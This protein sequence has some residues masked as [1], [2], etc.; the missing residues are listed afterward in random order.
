MN[1][2]FQERLENSAWDDSIAKNVYGRFEKRRKLQ[3]R[4][5]VSIAVLAISVLSFWGYANS[6]SQSEETQVFADLF[7][8]F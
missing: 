3:Q 6:V 1:K 5:M 4:V 2:P 8:D 7:M